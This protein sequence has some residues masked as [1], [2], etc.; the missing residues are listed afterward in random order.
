MGVVG[1]GSLCVSDCDLLILLVGQAFV[2]DPV[3]NT[4]LGTAHRL[5]F[6]LLVV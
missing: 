3:E 2:L 1:G 4:L 6:C 5:S